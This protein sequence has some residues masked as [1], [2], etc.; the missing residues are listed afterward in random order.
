[1]AKAPSE[2][3]PWTVGR[4]ESSPASHRCRRRPPGCDSA[5]V[6]CC[7]VSGWPARHD[8]AFCSTHELGH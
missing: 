1:M 4:L 6:R 5:G 8:V 3:G 7:G 2:R